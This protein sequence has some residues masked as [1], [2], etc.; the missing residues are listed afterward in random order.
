MQASEPIHSD[1]SGVLHCDEAEARK[2]A[3]AE[4]QAM[5]AHLIRDMRTPIA[6][7]RLRSRT[8]SFVRPRGLAKVDIDVCAC[9]VWQPH[10]NNDA[11]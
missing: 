3:A 2:P 6:V 4:P 1:Y 9:N 11:M 10:M 5:Q 8:A 7:A